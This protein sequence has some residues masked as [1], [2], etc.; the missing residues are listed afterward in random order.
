[1]ESQRRIFSWWGIVGFQSG[2]RQILFNGKGA[3]DL[4][5]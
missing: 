5:M 4:D 3:V 2:V 1:M